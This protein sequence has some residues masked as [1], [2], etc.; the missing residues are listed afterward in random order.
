MEK[1]KECVTDVKRNFDFRGQRHETTYGY[2]MYRDYL[3]D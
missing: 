3:V 1:L 2:D